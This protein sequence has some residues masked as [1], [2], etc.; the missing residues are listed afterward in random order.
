MF[1]FMKNYSNRLVL[2]RHIIQHSKLSLA[3]GS[4][5]LCKFS[6]VEYFLRVPKVSIDPVRII[7]VW[8]CNI[9]LVGE[10]EICCT[11]N[12]KLK[13]YTICILPFLSCD[14]NNIWNLLYHGNL[15]REIDANRK[16]S[17]W[18]MTNISQEILSQEL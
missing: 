13:L 17:F 10:T 6:F 16:V 9:E 14:E 8:K 18:K 1:L 3:I 7:W 4:R 5:S 11:N 15:P 2:R 12:M